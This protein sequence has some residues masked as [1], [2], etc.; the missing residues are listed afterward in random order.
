MQMRHHE[1]QALALKTG[2][3]SKQDRI[4]NME[5]EDLGRLVAHIESCS[6]CNRTLVKSRK[7]YASK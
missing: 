3:S 2:L 7:A 5:D 6:S 1:I 4:G